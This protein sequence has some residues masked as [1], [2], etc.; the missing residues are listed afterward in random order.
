M[1]AFS[2][3]YD[4]YGGR[5]RGVADLL[6]PDVD[7]GIDKTNHTSPGPLLAVHGHNYSSDSREV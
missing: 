2:S 7:V 1:G 3:L 4:L 6:C 5:N